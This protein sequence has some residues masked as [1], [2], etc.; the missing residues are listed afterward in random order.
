MD[1]ELW[2]KL[3]RAAWGAF[4]DVSHDCVAPRQGS[5]VSLPD[6]AERDSD[7]VRAARADLERDRTNF[8]SGPAAGLRGEALGPMPS[9]LDFVAAPKPVR[10]AHPLCLRTKVGLVISTATVP[11]SPTGL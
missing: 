7:L 8:A 1:S 5:G 10:V 3:C 2:L 11:R 6:N 4:F 9:S